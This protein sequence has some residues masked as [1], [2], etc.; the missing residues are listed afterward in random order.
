MPTKGDNRKT[1]YAC[2]LYPTEEYYKLLMKDMGEDFTK[3]YDGSKGWGSYDNK[4][5]E[6]IEQSFVPCL[7]SPLHFKDIDENGK[8][9]KPHFHAIFMWGSKKDFTSQVKPFFETFGGVP[10][11]ENAQISSQRGYAR[12]LCHLDVKA[13]DLNKKPRYSSKYVIELSGADYDN[14][15][16]LVS[17][18][19]QQIKEIFGFIR[20]YNICSFA[21]LLDLLENYNLDWFNLVVCSRAYIVEKYIKSYCWEIGHDKEKYER[22]IDCDAEGRLFVT[23][24]EGKHYIEECD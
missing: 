22:L 23:D 3:Y 15:I 4:S 5:Y 2:L 11:P 14:L 7:I 20:K 6:I 21:H 1:F 17:D 12:Y 8:Y 18:D 9:K 16:H 10:L 24:D 13:S 19:K